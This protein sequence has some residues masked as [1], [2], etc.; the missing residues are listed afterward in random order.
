MPEDKRAKFLKIYANIPD[1]LREDIIVVVND[2]T[3]T[4][5]AAYFEVKNKTKLGEKALKELESTGVI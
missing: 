4:W 5:N 1:S 3:Y 2:K